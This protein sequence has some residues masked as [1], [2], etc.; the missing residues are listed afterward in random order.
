M[1]QA[2]IKHFLVLSQAQ[3]FEVLRKLRTDAAHLGGA[4]LSAFTAVYISVVLVAFPLLASP[5]VELWPGPGSTGLGLFILLAGMVL[6]ISLVRHQHDLA[7][8][9]TRLA[10]FE[11]ALLQEPESLALRLVRSELPPTN[12]VGAAEASTMSVPQSGI[13]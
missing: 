6:A 7:R 1:E 10:F 4:S 11:D 3:Q 5:I 2:E 8:S 9:A 12:R 13:G